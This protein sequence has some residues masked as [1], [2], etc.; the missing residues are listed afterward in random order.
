MKK[1]DVQPKN[2]PLGSEKPTGQQNV[3]IPHAKHR[4]DRVFLHS[5]SSDVSELDE[6]N[7]VL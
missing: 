4:S 1:S 5:E 7:E 6:K 2:T 3:L